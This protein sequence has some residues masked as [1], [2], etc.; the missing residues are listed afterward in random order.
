MGL[1]LTVRIQEVVNQENVYML[2]LGERKDIGWI[3]EE[4]DN[5]L[6][7]ARWNGLE[8]NMDIIHPSSII[9]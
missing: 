6:L 5:D 2:Q 9:P 4:V 1:S 7:G 3:L 8:R